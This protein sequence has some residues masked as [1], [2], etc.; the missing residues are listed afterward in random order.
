VEKRRTWEVDTE[1]LSSR[2]DAGMGDVIDGSR[3]ECHGSCACALVVGMWAGE[4]CVCHGMCG[5]VVVG[6]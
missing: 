6:P 2:S 4:F 3:G 1:T 5:V